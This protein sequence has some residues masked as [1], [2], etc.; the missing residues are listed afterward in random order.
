MPSTIRWLAV[1]AS[2]GAI[3]ALSIVPG[4]QQPGDSAFVWAFAN[5]P[6]GF[7]KSM[8]VVAYG[9]L[10]MLLIWAMNFERGAGKAA[11]ILAV[12]VPAGLGAFLEWIQLSVPGRFGSLTDVGLNSLGSALGLVTAIALARRD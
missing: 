2:A 1:I 3:I 7:Q 8:H 5:T 10:A 4:D 12:L 11:R 6:P 9:L